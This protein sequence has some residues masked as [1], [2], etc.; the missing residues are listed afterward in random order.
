MEKSW[1]IQWVGRQTGK[2]PSMGRG[3]DGYFLE[4]HNPN[5]HDDGAKLKPLTPEGSP[6][7]YN[8]LALDRVKYQVWPVQTGLGAKGLKPLLLNEY[9]Y[10]VTSRI[11]S[12]Y[13]Y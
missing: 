8:T 1:K 12:S 5:L 2:K 10:K 4:P 13:H 11:S 6:H 7:E 3:G 9:N